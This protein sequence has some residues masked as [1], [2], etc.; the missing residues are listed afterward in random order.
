MGT[1]CLRVFCLVLSLLPL[2]MPNAV[3]GTEAAS[4]SARAAIEKLVQRMQEADADGTI[5]LADSIE[6]LATAQLG[7]DD[8]LIAMALGFKGRELIWKGQVAE[9]ESS[10]V[11]AI[12]IW[13]TNHGPACPQQAGPM[14]VLG[15]LYALAH[16]EAEAENTY[17]RALAIVEHAPPYSG[18]W[19]TQWMLA[20]LHNNLANLCV[21]QGRLDDARQHYQEALHLWTEESGKYSSEAAVARMNLAT[22][23]FDR[24]NYLVAETELRLALDVFESSPSQAIGQKTNAHDARLNLAWTCL[25]LGREDEARALFDSALQG[26]TQVY[27]PGT[28][29]TLGALDIGVSL[30]MA[31]ANWSKAAELAEQEIQIVERVDARNEAELSKCLLDL[32]QCQAELGEFEQSSATFNRAYALRQS[33][34]ASA[35]SYASERTK[36]LYLRHFPI[37]SGDQLSLAVRSGR[38]DA[39]ASALQAVLF[40]KA[41]VLDALSKERQ[42]A[43]CSGTPELR[44]LLSQYAAT[45]DAISGLAIS[46]RPASG[47]DEATPLY[48][49][50]DSLELELSQECSSFGNALKEAPVSVQDVRVSLPPKGVLWEYVRYRPP[51]SSRHS[52]GV[53]PPRY[54]AFTLDAAGRSSMV[55]LGPAHVIDSLVERLHREIPRGAGVLLGDDE[56]SLEKELAGITRRLY[57]TVFAP[58]EGTAA[59]DAQVFVSPDG[60]LSLLPFEILPMPDGRYAVEHY[61]FT[62]LSSGRDLL[63]RTERQPDQAKG[64]AIFAAPDYEREQPVTYAQVTGNLSGAAPGQFRGPSDRTECLSDPFTPLPAAAKEGQRV[65]DL[66]STT[67]K[68][69]VTLLTGSYA[70]EDSLKHLS[71]PPR[72]LH[73]ATHG[74]FCSKATYSDVSQMTESPLLYS[75]LALA[76]SNRTIENPATAATLTEDGILTALE[77][78]GL[79]L[80]GTDLV[81]LGSCRAGLGTVQQGEG[82][83]GLRRAFQLAGARSVIMSMFDVPDMTA[84]D[85][86]TRFYTD[87]LS[88]TTKSKALRNAMLAE[89]EARRQ[90]H[91]AAHPLFWGGFVLAG[92]PN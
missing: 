17:L 92:D 62:Y 21:Q 13:T 73:L 31:A 50:K 28:R 87:W 37:V 12:H 1:A 85:L 16:R 81:V 23:E 86:M 27:G 9:A 18:R 20:L 15:D 11:R 39:V 5:R 63:K 88:G 91:G 71:P 41:C 54:L 66:L 40:G 49:T 10:L 70:T 7:A 68:G 74:Y 69:R 47:S 19:T 79:S 34:L 30:E 89:L 6:S 14:R 26:Y 29:G 65:A 46:R 25:Q 33:F 38:P 90:R 48:R 57:E 72:V 53:L 80:M 42:A 44:D 56:Q 51:A 8:T 67:M 61:E 82:V 43:M 55:D 24:G 52:D 4:D 3:N 75:G 77:I 22:L 2:A 84:R 83:Y 45:C 35:F 78:S 58:L 60:D 32:A 64:A 76:G 36:L 59:P